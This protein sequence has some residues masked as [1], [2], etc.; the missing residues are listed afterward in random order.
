[1]LVLG[2]CFLSLSFAYSPNI[3]RLANLDLEAE[4][5]FVHETVEFAMEQLSHVLNEFKPSRQF[6]R[7]CERPCHMTTSSFGDWTIGFYTGILWQLYGLTKNATMKHWAKA[8]TLELEPVK[9]ITSNHDI[10]C[11]IVTAFEWALRLAPEE[12]G[13]YRYIVIDGARSLASRFNKAVGCIKSWE[14]A[15]SQ[16]GKVWQFPVIIDNMMN[17]QLLMLGANLTDDPEE[18][19]EFREIAISHSE[20]TRQNH[21]RADHGSFHLV[22]YDGVTGEVLDRGT[23]QGWSDDSTWVRGHSWGMYGFARMH[24]WTGDPRFIK[25]STE[26]GDFWLSQPRLPA[27]GVPY[28]D[29]NGGQPGYKR[30]WPLQPDKYPYP[31]HVFPV[32]DYRDTAGGAIATASFFEMY[33][34]TGNITFLAAAVDGLHSLAGKDYLV[35]RGNA[36]HLL[37]QHYVGS[38]PAGYDVDVSVVYADFYFLESLQYYL[39]WLNAEKNRRKQSEGL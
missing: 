26:L 37:L 32:S 5:Q 10:G 3:S 18:A 25:W 4:S 36:C 20:K 35:E 23:V 1:M 34:Y 19:K 29:F 27:D 11:S 8:W 24:R 39:E 30:V 9:Y 17:V 12:I 7:A 6:P 2:A 22:N 21:I 16:T 28:W 38:F 14:G 31:P 15:H 13:F 33:K